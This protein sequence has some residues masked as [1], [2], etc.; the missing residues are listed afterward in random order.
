VDPFIHSTIHL[1]GAVL[2]S[3]NTRTTLTLPY[4]RCDEGDQSNAE[5]KGQAGSVGMQDILGIFMGFLSPRTQEPGYWIRQYNL[6]P[7]S[8]QFISQFT[9]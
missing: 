2:N 4:A 1:H 3:L 6:L 5:E 8:F 9:I 7:D